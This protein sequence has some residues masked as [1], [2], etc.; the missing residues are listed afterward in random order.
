MAIFAFL[1]AKGGVGKTTLTVNFAAL[2]TNIRPEDTVV[3]LDS[4][5]KPDSYNWCNKRKGFIDR[6]AVEKMNTP[7]GSRMSD[8]EVDL[9]RKAEGKGVNFSSINGEWTR[10]NID[11]TIRSLSEDYDHVIVDAGGFFSDEM[12]DAL[13]NCDFALFPMKRGEFDR[14]TLKKIETAV[15]N[16]KR[17][18]K[19]M[20]ANVVLNEASSHP[21]SKNNQEV[22]DE[23]NKSE[24][25]KCLESHVVTREA[26]IESTKGISVFEMEDEKAKEDLINIFNELLS[27]AE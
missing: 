6:Y 18:N 21:R 16:A 3:I 19:S 7:E 17:W 8:R 11:R 14:E 5:P 9:L 20:V 26:F 23:V 27:G 12:T 22:K 2:I 1:Q 15:S 24:I 13:L 25:I 10:G 4:D